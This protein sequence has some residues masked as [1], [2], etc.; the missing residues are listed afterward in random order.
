MG[1]FIRRANIA[2][3]INTRVGR[4]KSIID[5]YSL[6]GIKLHVDR[7]QVQPLD[8]RGATHSEQD[9]IHAELLLPSI[10]F[11]PKHFVLAVP[12]HPGDLTAKDEGDP[13]P[14]QGGLDE[15][16]GVLI[17]ADEN[18]G[19]H[20]Q[21]GDLRPKA[22]KRLGEFTADRTGADDGQPFGQF[23]KGKDGFV[24]QITRFRQTGNRQGHGPGTRGDDRPTETQTPP[25]DLH[26]VRFDKTP[27]AQ[28]DIHAEFVPVALCRVMR[29]DFRAEPAHPFHDRR[30]I[31]SGSR[32][33]LDSVLVCVPDIRNRP[34]RPEQSFGRH[35]ADVQAVAAQMFPFHQGNLRSKTGRTGCRNQA[36]RAA[37]QDDQVV[38]RRG[39]RVRPVT[40]MD[41]G[42]KSLVIRVFRQCNGRHAGP[43]AVFRAP[44]NRVRGIGRFTRRGGQRKGHTRL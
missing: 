15:G 35:A 24:G 7:L 13:V 28:K 5:L 38:T 37:T 26:A 32:R 31:H 17:L 41:V 18:L 9:G 23:G 14:N 33:H 8:V 34:S 30:E 39:L 21:E 25:V 43:P 11:Y 2:R 27:L 16:C 42:N 3:G 12:L 4:L 19:H 44:K 22:G 20:F 6:F 1:E 36:G 10:F 40:G 29:T